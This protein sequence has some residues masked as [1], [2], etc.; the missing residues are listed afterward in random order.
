[1]S[2]EVYGLAPARRRTPCQQQQS[3]PHAALLMLPGSAATDPH[4]ADVVHLCHFDNL[5]SPSTYI[6]SCPRGNAL[7]GAAPGGVPAEQNASALLYGAGGMQGASLENVTAA[8]HVDYDLGTNDWTV[9]IAARPV[10]TLPG[11]GVL[12]D[13][14]TNGGASQYAPEIYITS[15]GQI[16]YYTNGA[17][18]IVSATGVIAL[19]TYYKIAACKASNVTRLFVDGVQVGSDWADSNTYIQCAITLNATQ[20]GFAPTNCQYDELRI[21]NGVGRYTSNYTP[22]SGPFPDS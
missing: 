4:F 5:A 15:S 3:A 10:V 11:A 14:R 22:Q 6:N 17:D 8:T 21:T 18:R 19:N 16:V 9:E 12:I 13:M 2:M 20:S 1:M 7:S